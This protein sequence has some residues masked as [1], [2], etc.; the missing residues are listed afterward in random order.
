MGMIYSMYA[1]TAISSYTKSW[2]YFIEHP[3][4]ELMRKFLKQ[5]LPDC[6]NSCTKPSSDSQQIT[7]HNL[8]VF[9]AGFY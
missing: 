2:Q 1:W 5:Q 8:R 7:S 3:C 6:I 9:L 4:P